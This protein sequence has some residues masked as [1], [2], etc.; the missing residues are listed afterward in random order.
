M[1][2]S[3]LSFVQLLKPGRL[4]IAPP[5]ALEPPAADRARAS[6][7]R[8][9]VDRGAHA[10]SS[11]PDDPPDPAGD[12]RAADSGGAGRAS[13]RG[14]R[15]TFRLAP[16]LRRRLSDLAL[17]RRSTTRPAESRSGRT[18]IERGR[19]WA[20]LVRSRGRRRRLVRLPAPARR[21]LPDPPVRRPERKAEIVLDR[22][23]RRRARERRRPGSTDGSSRGSWARSRSSARCSTSGPAA[24]SSRARDEAIVDAIVRG[25]ALLTRMDGEWW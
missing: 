13:S 10:A 24:C 7:R 6:A 17:R 2:A 12:E 4:A 20:E 23:R 21:V 16:E 22:L 19:L 3:C 11:R 9:L 15:R 1:H 25:D 5:G 8:G 14:R 18:A